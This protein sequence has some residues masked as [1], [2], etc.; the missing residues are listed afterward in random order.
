[1]RLMCSRL[2]QLRIL[3]Y[4]KRKRRFSLVKLTSLLVLSFCLS[5][6]SMLFFEQQEKMRFSHMHAPYCSALTFLVSS[7]VPPSIWRRPLLFF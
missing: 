7:L 5:F 6:V 1:M 4:V 3:F 2:D